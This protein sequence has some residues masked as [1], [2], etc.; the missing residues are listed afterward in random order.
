MFVHSHTEFYKQAFYKFVCT[1]ADSMSPADTNVNVK[2]SS[3]VIG[4]YGSNNVL[5]K[6]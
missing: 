2:N 1:L 3:I 6:Y 5:K 4:L